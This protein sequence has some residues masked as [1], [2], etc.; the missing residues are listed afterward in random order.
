MD[1]RFTPPKAKLVT[2]PTWGPPPPCKQALRW[3]SFS[4]LHMMIY[5][6]ESNRCPAIL[7][8]AGGSL[9]PRRSWLCQSW[10]LPWAVMSPGNTH[11]QRGKREPLGT[12]LS[13]GKFRLFKFKRYQQNHTVKPHFTDTTLFRTVFFVHGERKPLHSFYT[14][15]FREL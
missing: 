15:I 2:S 8:S 3:I 13:Q 5:R 11:W 14:V 1:R 9:V 4:Q 10:T 12:K 7:M 6:K